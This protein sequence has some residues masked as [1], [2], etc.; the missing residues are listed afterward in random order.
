MQPGFL[1]SISLADRMLNGGFAEVQA[2]L[3]FRK[4]GGAKFPNRCTR[5]RRVDMQSPGPIGKAMDLFQER[6]GQIA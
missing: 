1:A 4:S 6:I 5:G 3:G 2:Y